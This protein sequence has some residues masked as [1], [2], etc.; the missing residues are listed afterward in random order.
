MILACE[1]TVLTN[2]GKTYSVA[3]FTPVKDIK[4]ASDRGLLV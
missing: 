4:P 2:D 3:A 1:V